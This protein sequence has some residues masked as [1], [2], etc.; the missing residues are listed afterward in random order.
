[1]KKRFLSVMLAGLLTLS[2][3]AEAEDLTFYIMRHGKTMLNTTDRVQGWADAVLT[4]PG[5]EVV[6]N[7]ARGLKDIAFQGVYSSDSGRA[8]QTTRMV[9]AEN[10]ATTAV[11]PVFD[12]RLREFNFGTY[13]GEPNP[14]MWQD[15]ATK[16]GITMDQF[17]NELSLKDFA[18][19]VAELD[20]AN[21]EAAKNWPAENYDQI[22]E[23]LSAS[24]KDMIAA[25]AAK[26]EGNVLV[27]SHGLSIMTML[28]IMD[29][30][31]VEPPEGLKNASV[32]IVHLK[33][34]VYTL[35][36]VNDLSFIEAGKE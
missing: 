32:S 27:V 24:I 13:E 26:G 10:K 35:E 16:L 23:R 8:I 34:G 11:E 36:S 1:M 14:V 9:L 21:P 20:A 25:E 15:V 31:Y 22:T 33:D 12:W 18:N 30:N 28:K 6:N 19:A 5:E 3:A 29:P 7:A 4:P 17:M 2:S